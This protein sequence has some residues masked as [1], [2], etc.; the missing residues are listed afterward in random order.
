MIVYIIHFSRKLGHAQHYIGKTEAYGR[1]LKAHRAGNGARILRAANEQ[2]IKWRVVARWFGGR[3]LEKKLKARHDT[4]A[5]C[6]V[7]QRKRAAYK[8]R[9]QRKK[10]KA[11]DGN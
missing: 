6:P 1:R 10:R 2:G 8:K 5:L 9:W 7:C 4:A 3:T 11:N